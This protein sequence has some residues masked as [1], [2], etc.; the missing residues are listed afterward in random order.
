MKPDTDERACM[1]RARLHE[2]MHGI[3][4]MA[5]ISSSRRKL[6]LLGI[7]VCSCT[8]VVMVVSVF[9]EL[10]WRTEHY[11]F[12]LADGAIDILYTKNS[13]SQDMVGRYVQRVYSYSFTMRPNWTR[14]GTVHFVTGPLWIPLLVTGL[15]TALLMWAKR[16]R[17]L[18]GHCS[19]GY[20][21]RGN[22]S[23]RCPECGRAIERAAGPG[24]R[25]GA[26]SRA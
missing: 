4:F 11:Q 12:V 17:L 24:A 5:S 13:Y 16:V 18:P 7:V 2:A 22:V 6:A 15:A 14:I 8:L 10:V 1:A 21:L 3:R 23:G 19:C 25:A 20:N 26:D 9:Y